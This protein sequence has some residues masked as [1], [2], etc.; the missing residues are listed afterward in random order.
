MA[1]IQMALM[2]SAARLVASFPLS[3][4]SVSA[5]A[6]SPNNADA[7]VE[8]RRDGTITYLGTPSGG[9]ST[10]WINLEGPTVGDNYWIRIDYADGSINPSANFTNM[11]YGVWYQL[12]ATRY[13]GISIDYA[14]MYSDVKVEI[15]TD[16]GGS[17]I[18]ATEPEINFSALVT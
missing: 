1:G 9:S 3:I 7:V 6:S 16:A 5:M 12:N 2:G 8:F 17:N 18:V 4:G 15:A 14:D 10:R 11:T 13:F